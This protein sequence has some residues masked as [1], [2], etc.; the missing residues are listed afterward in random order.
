MISHKFKCIFVH[1]P[2]CGGS[3]VE[4]VIWPNKEDRTESNLW[5]GFV[6]KFENKYQTGGLQHLL[7]QQIRQEVGPE[8]FSDYFK[9]TMVRNPWDKAVSQ[10]TYMQKR[11]DLRDDIG[12]R[13]NDEFKTYLS[14]IKKTRHVQWMPQHFFV[15]SDEGEV[16]VDFIG[17]FER[18]EDDIHAILKKLHIDSV[19]NIPHRKKSLRSHYRDYY[20]SESQ[21]MVREMYKL[22]VLAFDYDF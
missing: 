18:F 14:L 17:R 8:V 1:I 11:K 7:A 13:K 21:E 2:K 9:F 22:D 3:S 5:M 10:F 16:L 12:M 6:S 15:M 4:D 19:E 20:D